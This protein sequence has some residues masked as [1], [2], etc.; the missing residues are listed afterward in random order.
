MYR[1]QVLVHV[2]EAVLAKLAGGVAERLKRF[3][4][5]GLATTDLMP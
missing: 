2:A 4:K 3:G 5:R 1:A